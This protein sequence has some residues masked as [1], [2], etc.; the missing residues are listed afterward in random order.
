MTR[1]ARPPERLAMLALVSF[2]FVVAIAAASP[3]AA[4]KHPPAAGK[5]RGWEPVATTT[6]DWPGSPPRSAGREP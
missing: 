1:L 3:T 2:A 6:A 4:G 5:H